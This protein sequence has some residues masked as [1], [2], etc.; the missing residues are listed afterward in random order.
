MNLK[1]NPLINSL[2]CCNNLCFPMYN[3][4]YITGQGI[5]IFSNLACIENTL[6]SATCSLKNCCNSLCSTNLSKHV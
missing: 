3:N 2:L 1:T 6:S 4:H 5:F